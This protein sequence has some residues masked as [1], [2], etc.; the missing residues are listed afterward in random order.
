M[1]LAWSP[2]P[3]RSVIA[4][5]YPALWNRTFPRSERTDHQQDA[6]STAEW[7]RRADTDGSL[8]KFLSPELETDERK[9]AEIE[10][11]ILGVV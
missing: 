7:L 3:G 10:G 2:L 5:V 6:F 9:A 1:K 4:E 11:W 8:E